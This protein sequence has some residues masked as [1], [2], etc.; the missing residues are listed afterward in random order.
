MDFYAPVILKTYPDVV[1]LYFGSRSGATIYYPNIDLAAIVPNDFDITRRPWYVAATPIRNPQRQAVWSAPYLDAALNGLVITCS[2]P[3]YD[4]Q[5][6]FRGVAAMDI[7]LTRISEI[8]DSI[9]VEQTGYAFLIDSEKRLIAM[10][11]R[12][13]QDL[14]ATAETLPS[15]NLYRKIGSKQTFQLHSGLQSLI[16]LLGRPEFR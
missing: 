8:V 15:V 13:Y 4:Q 3:V 1:A 10:P 5:G 7:Q 6:A 12:G 14:G 11:R 16:W 9:R 2:V